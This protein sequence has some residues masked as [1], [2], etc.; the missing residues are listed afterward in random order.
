MQCSFILMLEFNIT[1][2]SI[3]IANTIALVMHIWI[4]NY[5][6]INSFSNATFSGE[7]DGPSVSSAFERSCF[8]FF[9]YIYNVKYS[10]LRFPWSFTSGKQNLIW[11]MFSVVCCSDQALHWIKPNDENSPAFFPAECNY[12]MPIVKDQLIENTCL[13]FQLAKIL[14]KSVHFLNSKRWVYF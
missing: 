11:K 13:C 7:Y 1:F 4:F 12:L 9:C 10:H 14:T 6:S 8:L 5:V 3:N 2:S